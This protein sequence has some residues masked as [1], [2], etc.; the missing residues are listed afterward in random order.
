MW[1]FKVMQLAQKCHHCIITLRSSIACLALHV[2][3]NLLSVISMCFPSLPQYRKCFTSCSS[4]F[5]Y[6]VYK[7]TESLH[8]MKL[9]EYLT[10][11]VCV[12]YLQINLSLIESEAGTVV[13]VWIDICQHN[14]EESGCFSVPGQ[15]PT[16]RLA[17]LKRSKIKHHLVRL[18]WWIA[19]KILRY[20]DMTHHH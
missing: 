19:H 12:L 6:K 4:D 11:S 18:L 8:F 14:S 15:P 2:G 20:N 1:K 7:T 9:K 16:S 17:E 3:H 10:W 13:S 5:Q